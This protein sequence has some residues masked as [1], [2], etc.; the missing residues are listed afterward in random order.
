MVARRWKLHDRLHLK[1]APAL[2]AESESSPNHRCY[3]AFLWQINR[4]CH[5]GLN[6]QVIFEFIPIPLALHEH[7]HMK[8]TS[9][10]TLSILP[11]PGTY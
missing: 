6:V 2:S 4:E 3:E 8:M 9:L 1:A 5:N 11:Y 10:K 7:L